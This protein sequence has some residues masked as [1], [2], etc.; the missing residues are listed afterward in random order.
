MLSREASAKGNRDQ[1]AT[2][3]REAKCMRGLAHP[4]VE[5]YA[6]GQTAP[7]FAVLAVVLAGGGDRPIAF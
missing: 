4:P 3:L 1:G 2:R 6:I 5:G 7:R